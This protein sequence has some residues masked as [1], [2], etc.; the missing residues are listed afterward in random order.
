MAKATVKE[1]EKDTLLTPVENRQ[2]QIIR[3]EGNSH[4]PVEIRQTAD[5]RLS[6][7]YK[8][9]TPHR[10]I[11]SKLE[12][13]LLPMVIDVP[14]DAPDFRKEASKFWYAISLKVPSEGAVL[15]IS[16]DENGVPYEPKQFIIYLWALTHPYVAKSKTSMLD[17]GKKRF[18]IHD[19]KRES[20]SLNKRVKSKAKAMKVF[21]KVMDDEE[22]MDRVLR[23]LGSSNPA[24]MDLESKENAL[25][26]LMENDPEKFHEVATDDSLKV[27]DFIAEAIS[28]E[29]LRQSGNSY[30]YMEE[31]IGENMDE[32]VAYLKDK[33]N[34][35]TL[36]DIRAKVEEQREL[37]GV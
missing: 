32:A 18:Y 17:S 34:S 4:V 9:G 2:V 25:N 12:K 24:K 27:K 37:E 29:V 7:V 6:S 3:K 5:H 8:D 36:N 16:V 19:P 11:S 35:G 22:H 30:F 26:R 21:V 33:K 10:G 14:A 20:A 1:E 28:T 15:N 13:F 31:R 23:V